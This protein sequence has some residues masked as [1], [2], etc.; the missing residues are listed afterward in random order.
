M[1]QTIPTIFGHRGAMSWEPENTVR[2]FRRA[3]ADG[4]DGIELDLRVSADGELVICH[5]AAVDRTTNGTGEIAELSLA[6]LTKLDAGEGEPIPTFDDA[7]GAIGAVPILAEI[8]APEA[9]EPLART[10]RDRGLI[11]QVKVI[12]FIDS[13][14]ATARELV[15]DAVRVLVMSE[16]S[17]DA[18]ERARVV[19]ASAVSPRIAFVTAEQVA[20]C[21]GAGLGVWTW[22]VNDADQVAR[23]LD[24]G[25][26][27]M[28]SDCPG[29]VRAHTQAYLTRSD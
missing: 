4:A 21:H 23:A 2:S 16:M 19:G 12:S 20:A 7:L 15:P 27:A 11:Q 5:D 24:L 6:Q 10:L 17:D 3:L 14:L 9:V 25:I 18:V 26:D 22:T 28:T 8:K 13:A 1:A 29:E